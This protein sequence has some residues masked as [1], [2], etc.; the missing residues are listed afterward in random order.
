M[1]GNST[2]N[3]ATIER[4]GCKNFEAKKIGQRKKE[5]F[6]NKVIDLT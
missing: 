1:L 5:T 4:I 6:T 3:L 2:I